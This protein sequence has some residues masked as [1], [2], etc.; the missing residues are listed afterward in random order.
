MIVGRQG[1]AFVVIQAIAI[2]GHAGH[3]NIPAHFAV[4]N[5]GGRFDLGASG[6]VLPIVSNVENCIERVAP[7]ALRTEAAS[8]RSATRLWTRLPKG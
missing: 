5:L 4:E 1:I 6:A 7:T 8:L 3:E 2:S